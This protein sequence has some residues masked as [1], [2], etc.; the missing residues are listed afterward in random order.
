[1]KK[2]AF[3]KSASFDNE[4][5]CLAVTH[6]KEKETKQSSRLFVFQTI[7]EVQAVYPTLPH[8]PCPSPNF[9]QLLHQQKFH[10]YNQLFSHF[11][12]SFIDPDRF[13]SKT[14]MMHELAFLEPQRQCQRSY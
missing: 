8:I 14:S 4:T 6:I 3:K 1:V 12:S 13:P 11:I 7:S 10:P 9:F 5:L 2:K